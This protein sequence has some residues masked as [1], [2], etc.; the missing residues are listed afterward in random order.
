MAGS[1]AGASVAGASVTAGASVA[2]GAQ[3]LRIIEATT[4]IASMRNERRL[5]MVFSYQENMGYGWM[6]QSAP[7]R[8]III[9]K[10][11]QGKEAV[12]ENDKF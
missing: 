4:S 6:G 9:Q 12:S 2:T 10:K 11:K 8:V 5:F 1:V 3:A 7:D